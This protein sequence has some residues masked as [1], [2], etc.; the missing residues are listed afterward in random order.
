MD[1]VSN[2]LKHEAVVIWDKR[3]ERAVLVKRNFM[4]FMICMG[5]MLGT[6][7]CLLAGYGKTARKYRKNIGKYTTKEAWEKYLTRFGKSAASGAQ[8][9]KK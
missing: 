6:L 1:P 4:Q 2:Y 8:S 7:F 3:T 5:Y 9:D